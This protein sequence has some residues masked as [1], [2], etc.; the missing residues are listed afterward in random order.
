MFVDGKPLFWDLFQHLIKNGVILLV[1]GDVFVD[2]EPL[3]IFCAYVH[4]YERL[5]LYLESKNIFI[6]HITQWSVGKR[7]RK[8]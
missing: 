8:S 1:M 4:I 3:T 6:I 2:P 7:E 5:Y